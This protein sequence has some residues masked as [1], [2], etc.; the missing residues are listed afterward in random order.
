MVR[1][2]LSYWDN[3]NLP[4]GKGR[5]A[6]LWHPIIGNGLGPRLRTVVMLLESHGIC[7]ALCKVKPIVHYAIMF[8]KEPPIEQ[9]YVM[10]WEEIKRK[11]QLWEMDRDKNNNDNEEEA[12]FSSSEGST[13]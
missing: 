12:E 7:M 4:D 3:P 13:Q 8:A 1:L 9:I 5:P 11:F 2:L 6:P 10:I